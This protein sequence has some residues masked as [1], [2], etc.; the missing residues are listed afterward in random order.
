[1]S[2][3]CPASPL[4]DEGHDV[5]IVDQ[6]ADPDWEA[7]FRRALAERPVCLGVTCM[8]GPQIL[9]ALDAC[10]I[11]KDAQP[12]LPIVWGGIHASLLPDQTLAHPLIDAVVRRRRR[13]ELPCARSR[14][15]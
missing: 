7:K 6:F 9:H 13:G 2:V 12:D 15:P 8:T 4:V 10:R 3:L 5:T 11:A 1:L 14:A